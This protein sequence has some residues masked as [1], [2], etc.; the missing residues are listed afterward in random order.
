MHLLESSI[1]FFHALES[2]RLVC[3]I[4]CWRLN[5]LCDLLIWV[6]C[7]HLEVM[8]LL[9][10]GKAP[11]EK[12]EQKKKEGRGRQIFLLLFCYFSQFPYLELDMINKDT[13]CF[14]GP[15]R[16]WLVSWFSI[17]NHTLEEFL[18][19]CMQ[20]PWPYM[21]WTFSLFWNFHSHNGIATLIILLL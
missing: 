8:S 15:Q 20:L 9:W 18:F 19:P 2:S 4:V 21:N 7:L 3:D 5:G 16:G 12:W 1:H 14:N 6:T 13:V 10:K 17:A 11:K